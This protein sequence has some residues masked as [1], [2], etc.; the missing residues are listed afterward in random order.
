MI[1]LPDREL[2]AQV[3]IAYKKLKRFVYYDKTNMFLRHALAEFEAT[4]GFLDRLGKI[5]EVLASGTPSTNSI[6]TNWVGKITVRVVPKKILDEESSSGAGKYITNST[7]ADSVQVGK[8]NYF[9]DCPI[10]IHVMDVFWVMQSGWLLDK[11]LSPKCYGSRLDRR[12]GRRDDKSSALFLKYHEQYSQW[13]DLG[14]SKAKQL[15]VEDKCNVF[16][17]GLDLER[18]YYNIQLDYKELLIAIL[19]SQGKKRDTIIF[20]GWHYKLLDCLELVHKRYR[21]EL[22]ELRGTSQEEPIDMGIPIGLNS[23]PILA[24][25]YVKCLD[26]NIL[27]KLRPAYY[28]R[29]VDD[30]LIVLP[31]EMPLLDKNDPI[32]SFLDGMLVHNGILGSFPE[33]KETYHVVGRETL[34][35]QKEKC[36]LQHFYKEYSIAGLLKFKKKLDET[37]SGFL[38]LP[39]EEADVSLEDVA[40][41]LLYEGPS[42][43][44]RSI[45][46]TAENRY[47]LAKHLARQTILHQ[48]T[49]DTIEDNVVWGVLKFFKGKNAIKFYE[50]WE[51]IFTFL[52][53]AK[54]NEYIKLLKNEIN[55]QIDSIQVNPSTCESPQ[56]IETQLKNDL[57]FHLKICE[58]ASKALVM[59]K[60]GLEEQTHDANLF[61]ISNLIRHHFVRTPLINYTPF[62]G[63]LNKYEPVKGLVIDTQRVNFSPRYVHFDE[64]YVFS[65]LGKT[66]EPPL[67]RFR[68]TQKIFAKFNGNIQHLVK[69]KSN[70]IAGTQKVED[71]YIGDQQAENA[72]KIKIGIANIKIEIENVKA[73]YRGEPKVT[74]K[75]MKQLSRLLNFCSSYRSPDGSMKIDLIVFPEVCIPYE[76][77]SLLTAWSRKHN[78]GL[79]CGLEHR[80]DRSRTAIN[81]YLA[82]LP[83]KS[84]TG[85]IT[86]VPIS[87]IKRYYSP[88][89]RFTLENNFLKVPEDALQPHQIIHWRGVSF[90]IFNCFELASIEDRSIL[91]SRIDFLVAIEANKDISY[92]SNII[93]ST[94]R[95]I[96]CI[97]I[98]VN[99]SNFGDSRIISPVESNKMNTLSIKGGNNDLVIV[100]DIDLGALREFQRLDYGLQKEHNKYKVT[101]PNFN[102]TE[103]AKR[104]KLGKGSD[105]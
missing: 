50:L 78:I 89:E 46:G 23:S 8:V 70:T 82:A 44:I 79:I 33:N 19:E 1:S 34:K 10:E 84:E 2:L 14:I 3:H 12:V 54:A 27:L 22:N 16:I 37:S 72:M 45:R 40:Y 88:S 49:S 73:S 68:K 30:I 102:R 76:W 93:E 11:T 13:R 92:F 95:D 9:I 32:Q 91:K 53:I 36:I 38:L 98:Q 5:S 43:K 61:R 63:Q 56:R 15:L 66:F 17:L 25:W 87:R 7:Q 21:T 48:F 18:F 105:D 67:E 71:I 77:V 104:I 20:N 58:S 69:W 62:K 75:R 64:C 103:L 100:G 94:V 47:E 31:E 65:I 81:E 60:A 99:D 51:R 29:Y 6:F 83:F 26:E 74:R 59:P 35:L 85:H 28:G 80:V 101:P 57:I 96:H 55:R 97:V 4:K 90:S 24:N 41:D 86:C 39:V 52:Y 42:N